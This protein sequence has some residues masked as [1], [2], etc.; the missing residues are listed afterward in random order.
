MFKILEVLGSSQDLP[1]DFFESSKMHKFYKFAQEWASSQEAKP[2]EKIHED[3]D[4]DVLKML[5]QCLALNPEG[6]CTAE[7]CLKNKAFDEI[8]G[9]YEHLIEGDQINVKIDQLKVDEN[10]EACDYSISKMQRY[11]VNYSQKI[12]DHCPLSSDKN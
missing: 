5:K 2:L 11:L 12:R 6:R 1:E 7:E 3:D 10:G 8:R 4:Q 9:Q